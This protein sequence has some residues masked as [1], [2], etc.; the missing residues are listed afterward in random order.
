MV[1]CGHISFS[2]YMV[3]EL[4][5]TAWNWA[6]AQFD[7]VLT[8]S[9]S[10][11]ADQSLG[12]L[13][14]A[15]RRCGTAVPLR[16]GARPHLDAQNGQ[17]SRSYLSSCR[18]PTK[19]P[20]PRTPSSNRYTDPGK[21]RRT[22][23]PHARA[24]LLPVSRMLL[25]QMTKQQFCNAS[26]TNA[27]PPGLFRRLWPYAVPVSRLITAIATIAVL[28]GALRWTPNAGEAQRNPESGRLGQPRRG[29]RRLLHSRRRTGRTRPQWMDRPAWQWLT[30]QGIPVS[31]DVAAEGGAGYAPAV[32]TAVCSRT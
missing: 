23:S 29:D 13:A 15:V 26:L 10:A 14:V 8:P 3:H 7:I 16:R 22:P 9:W 11:Q 31:A 6:A 12:V 24:E 18:T 20:E 21:C 28:L 32:T 27:S 5:H 17:G 19:R 25:R 30:Q 4:V 1:Y 2:L